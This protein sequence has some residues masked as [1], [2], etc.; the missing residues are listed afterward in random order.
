MDNLQYLAEEEDLDINITRVDFEEH[1]NELFQRCFDSIKE[2]MEEA[3]LT[4]NDI[5]DIVLGGGIIV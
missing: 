3:S 2:A 5:D 1:C 4:K